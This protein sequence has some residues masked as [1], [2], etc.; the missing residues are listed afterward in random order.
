MTASA[1][2]VR[3]LGRAGYRVTAPRRAVAGLVAARTGPFTAADLVADARAQRLG[4]G[5]AT[6]FRALDLLTELRLVERLDLPSGAHAYVACESAPHHH[7][8]CT[9]CGRVTE[10]DCGI[11]PIARDVEDRTGYR[12]DEHRLELFGVC[13]ACLRGEPSGGSG[14]R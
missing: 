6:V 10:V 14:A 3:T 1:Q 7:V 12:V 13:P 11:G 9:R 5:R 4:L 2:A 8:V